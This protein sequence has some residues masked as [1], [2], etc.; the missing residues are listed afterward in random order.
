MLLKGKRRPLRRPQAYRTPIASCRVVHQYR[1]LLVGPERGTRIHAHRSRG[2]GASLTDSSIRQ[3]RAVGQQQGDSVETLLPQ[4]QRRLEILLAAARVLLRDRFPPYTWETMRA[5]QPQQFASDDFTRNYQSGDHDHA[6]S[7]P[8]EKSR[9]SGD[10]G[11]EL[12]HS[13]PA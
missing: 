3:I 1:P 10:S 4:A 11:P 12:T 9:G 8:G 5:R 6:T 2:S 13:S 7:N